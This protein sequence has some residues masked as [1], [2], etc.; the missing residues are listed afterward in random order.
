MRK[1]VKIAGLVLAV[2]LV[3]AQFIQPD[4]NL[5]EG[6]N[7]HDILGALE[8]PDQV[9]GL[10]KN[11]CFDCHSNH[12]RYPWYSKISP[13]SWYLNHHVKEGKEALN[14]DEFGL[15]SQRKMITSLSNVCEVIESGTMPLASYRLI[16]RDAVPGGD[17]VTAICDWSE[18]ESERLISAGTEH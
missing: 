8:V 7:E 9:A 11:S 17:Q 18:S 1:P 12:T 15:L 13:V 5:S 6:P 3:V 16:H 10:L 4:K 2:A 14:F